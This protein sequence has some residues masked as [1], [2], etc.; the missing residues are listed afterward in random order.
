MKDLYSSYIIDFKDG[1]RESVDTLENFFNRYNEIHKKG[2]QDTV[3]RWC[4]VDCA[5][6]ITHLSSYGLDE[7]F[8]WAVEPQTDGFVVYQHMR[9]KPHFLTY[10]GIHHDLKHALVLD[11]REAKRKLLCNNLYIAIIPC[12]VA[13]RDAGKFNQEPVFFEKRPKS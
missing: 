4:A 12:T 11:E 6:N 3:D 10:G 9:D 8:I 2:E 1:T 7:I 13:E 5:H